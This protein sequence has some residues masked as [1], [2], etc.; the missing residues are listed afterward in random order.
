MIGRRRPKSGAVE[1]PDDPEAA[2]RS[3]LLWLSRR[4]HSSAELFGKLTVKGHSAEAARA[5]IAGLEAERL[6]DDARFLDNFVRSHAARGHGPMRIRQELSGLG[7]A[8]AV[9]DGALAAGPDFVA[10][11]RQVRLRKFGAEPATSWA[12]RAKQARFL[13]YRGFSSDHIRLA[14]GHDPEAPE[15]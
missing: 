11:C 1:N 7:F 10:V 13:Q 4:D 8:P 15:T 14:T 9:I 6:L 3:A 2:R 5:A 12:E